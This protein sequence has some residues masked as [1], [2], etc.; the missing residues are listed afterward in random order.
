M[1]ELLERVSSLAA[2]FGGTERE[3]RL[4]RKKEEDSIHRDH[5][6]SKVTHP[7]LTKGG[8]GRGQLAADLGGETLKAEGSRNIWGKCPA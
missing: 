2:A 4:G 7:S 5:K 8:T 1:I 3:K 6:K